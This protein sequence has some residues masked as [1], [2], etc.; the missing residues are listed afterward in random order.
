MKKRM[1][2]MT[3]KKSETDP[4]LAF[5]ERYRHLFCGVQRGEKTVRLHTRKGEEILTLEGVYHKGRLLWN[6][7]DPKVALNTVI[8]RHRDGFSRMLEG[9]DP[10]TVTY[11]L[12]QSLEAG[13]FSLTPEGDML[14]DGFFNGEVDKGVVLDYLRECG[15]IPLD[16]EE[17]KGK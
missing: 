10:V 15:A 9:R 7:Y 14:M 17:R 3:A 12:W 16:Y 8:H 13:F 6:S 4:V 2:T 1:K 5:V 11:C